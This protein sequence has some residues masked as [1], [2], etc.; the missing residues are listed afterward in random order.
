MTYEINTLKLAQLQQ[1]GD[2]VSTHSCFYE[3]IEC[4]ILSALAKEG[5]FCHN[6]WYGKNMEKIS[7]EMHDFVR[8]LYD[9]KPEDIGEKNALVRP[10]FKK[11]LLSSGFLEQEMKNW[12]ELHLDKI[13]FQKT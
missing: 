9:T 3:S 7:K 8:D 5:I 13:I 10:Y 11:I 2:M 1:R 6:K 4:F 12:E